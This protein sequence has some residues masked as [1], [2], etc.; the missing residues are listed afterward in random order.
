[1]ENEF[2]GKTILVTGGTGSIGSRIVRQLLPFEPRQIRVFSRDETKQFE[3]MHQ[4]GNNHGISWL[5]G[6]IRDQERLHLALEGVDIVFHAAAMK[7]VISCETNP[8]EAVKTNIYGTQNLIYAAFAN[9]VDK[10]IM[11]STDKA[12]NPT[13]VLGCTKLLAEKI[14]LA[15]CF[16]KGHK[17]TK[18]SC[19]RFGNVLFSRGSVIPLFINQ[20]KQGGPVTITDDRMERF[21]M[22]TTQAVDLVFKAT[23]MT[24]DREIFVLKMPALRLIDLVQVLI[25]MYAPRFGRDPKSIG[26]ERI[27]KKPG[28]RLFEKLLS[29][30]ESEYAW[31]TD[32]MFIVQSVVG[33][34]SSDVAPSIF[35]GLK[36]SSLREVSTEQEPKLDLAQIRKILE[37][38]QEFFVS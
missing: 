18:F 31:E 34:E 2:K 17:K 13:N 16:Y 1:M 19:V 15:S 37:Q 23:A 30:D 25:D 33:V 5:I 21:I 35:S 9:H 3:L 36:K 27:G 38:E 28:E 8:F 24:V 29:Y 7:H 20:I 12:V 14:V 4:L 11:I 6:D 22:S 26:I 10:L 32:E